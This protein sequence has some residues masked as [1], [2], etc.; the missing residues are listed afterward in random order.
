LDD[1]PSAAVVSVVY[2]VTSTA[3]LAKD[4][5]VAREVPAIEAELGDMRLVRSEAGWLLREFSDA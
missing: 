1:D 5:S 4:G 2:D 3:Q